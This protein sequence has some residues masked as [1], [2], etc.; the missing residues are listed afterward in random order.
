MEGHKREGQRE[1][2]IKRIKRIKIDY[3]HVPIPLDKYNQMY[4]KHALVRK[5]VP[6]SASHNARTLGVHLMPSPL[7]GY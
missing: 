1:K 2:R 3:V 5:I 7:K 6:A 4:C